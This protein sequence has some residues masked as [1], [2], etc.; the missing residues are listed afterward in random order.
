M[1]SIIDRSRPDSTFVTGRQ[2]E[3]IKP[4]KEIRVTL[5][6]GSQL[7]GEYLGIDQV[8]K[9]EYAEMYESFRRQD[10]DGASLPALGSDVEIALKSGQKGERQL[11]GFDRKPELG[12]F[13]SVGWTRDT[14]SGTVPLSD[15]AR[16]T[17][18]GGNVTEGESL[19]SLASE[20]RIPC[21]S[22]MAVQDHTSTKRVAFTRVDRVA[23]KNKKTARW[24][25]L[26]V[27]AAIDV[28]AI[29]VAGAVVVRGLKG[30]D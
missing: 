28:A 14:T 5:T 17:D 7:T 24:V 2:L 18:A 8:P 3:R 4:G 9:G 25:G 27:G 12:S 21:L 30:Y 6:D 19:R 23:M 11:W 16:I 10:P 1:G 13:I 26:G 29:A 22:A 15:I 20:N